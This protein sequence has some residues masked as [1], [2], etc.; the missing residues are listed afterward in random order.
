MKTVAVT[1]V[2]IMTCLTHAASATLIVP[3]SQSRTVSASAESTL[4][5]DPP[6][7]DSDS[8]SD[9]EMDGGQFSA[10]VSASA[11]CS[12]P[13]QSAASQT[14]TA[15]GGQITGV[16]AVDARGHS[17]LFGEGLS[18]AM[19]SLSVAFQISQAVNYSFEGQLLSNSPQR[20]YGAGG[21]IYLE[22]P[23]DND[24][25][26][27]SIDPLKESSATKSLAAEGTLFPGDY[28]LRASVTGF[29]AGAVDGVEA[30]SEASEASFDFNFLVIPEPS[31]GLL[32]SFGLPLLLTG[33]RR[34]H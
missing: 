33:H 10:S 8:A 27:L 16:G 20:L 29:P 22:G 2:T 14:S 31:S 21:I 1:F 9:L 25:F 6:C 23:T 18:S 15:L 19:S 4:F 11:F 7:T 34:R 32:L 17:T 28:V 12:S 5:D 30:A 13:T 24:V 26:F 3:T